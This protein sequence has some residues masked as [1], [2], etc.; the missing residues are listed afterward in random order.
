MSAVDTFEW[1]LASAAKNA[2]PDVQRYIERQRQY[3]YTLRS[4]D[5]RQRFVNDL[6]GEI[7]LM[8]SSK[9]KKT[10]R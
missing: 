5:E 8:L 3:L 6:M 1:Y 2:S 10:G 4:E 9:E 7:S